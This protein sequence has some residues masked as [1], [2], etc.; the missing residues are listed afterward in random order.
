[1]RTKLLFVGIVLLLFVGKIAFSQSVSIEL[2]VKWEK[3]FDIFKEDSIINIPTLNI[4]YRNNSDTNY[5]FQKVSSERKSYPM[6]PWGSLLQYPIEEYLNPNYKRRAMLH[7]DY[8][9][10]NYSV[11]IGETSLYSQ[12]WEAMKDTIA[13]DEEYEI[14]FIN[15]KLADI[16]YYMYFRQ[17]GK[18]TNSKLFFS[19]S[20]IENNKISESVKN[21]FVFLKPNETYTDTYNL[22]AFKELGGN[23]TFQVSNSNLFDYVFLESIWDKK[24]NRFVNRQKA[25]PKEIE[26][27]KLYSGSFNTNKV[28]LELK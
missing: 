18:D 22:V 3:G 21:A 23:F 17:Y 2:S 8:T 20:E 10:K 25:L 14:D 13:F 7:G 6:L 5:Y 15:D 12:G 26:G 4:T 1:M 11:F 28:I 9:N 24:K 19:E 16:Y 27:Y